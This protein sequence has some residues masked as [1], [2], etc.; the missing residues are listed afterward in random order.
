M[1]AVFFVF[2]VSFVQAKCDFVQDVISLDDVS[3][4]AAISSFKNE[5]LGMAVLHLS[6]KA[7]QTGSSLQE[8]AKQTR[9]EL[10]LVA[11]QIGVETC[12]MH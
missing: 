4:E 8:V 3:G 12:C 2:F 5:S 11:V 10:Y 9:C 6:H 1:V 7:L